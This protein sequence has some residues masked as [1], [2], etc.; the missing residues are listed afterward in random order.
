MFQSFS[1][2][3]FCMDGRCEIICAQI[4]ISAGQKWR[5]IKKCNISYYALYSFILFSNVKIIQHFRQELKV[6]FI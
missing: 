6:L 4:Q 5:E 1:T 2:D 3:R